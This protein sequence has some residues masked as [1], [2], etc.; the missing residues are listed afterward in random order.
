MN[1]IN[2]IYKL[3]NKNKYATDK[4]K[5]DIN[6]ISNQIDMIILQRGI[7]KGSFF[8]YE[9]LQTLLK[10]N[11]ST[12]KTIV[13]DSDNLIILLSSSLLLPDNIFFNIFKIEKWGP[14]REPK[15]NRELYRVLALSSYLLDKIKE[16]DFHTI[17]IL[18]NLFKDRLDVSLLKQNESNK[19]S[20]FNK[21][22]R[23]LVLICGQFRGPDY[24]EKL[25]NI[26]NS[27]TG[28]KNPKFIIA[29]WGSAQVSQNLMS[30]FKETEWTFR[31]NQQI[32]DHV[33]KIIS[34]G[35]EFMKLMPETYNKLL[36]MEQSKP[37]DTKSIRKIFE[38]VDIKLIDEG[39]FNDDFFT[40]QATTRNGKLNQFKMFYQFYNSIKDEILEKNI[41]NRIVKIRPDNVIVESNLKQLPKL[42][43]NQYLAELRDLY[44]EDSLFIYSG[45][46]FITNTFPLLENI[47][48]NKS[49]KTFSAKD[50]S[51]FSD[52]HLTH[53][54]W[55]VYSKNIP[56]DISNYLKIEY[57]NN[58]DKKSLNF[59]DLELEVKND[60]QNSRLKEDEKNE[61]LTFF[62]DYFFKI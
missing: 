24:L 54:L 47:V 17:I 52:A 16:D 28:L 41:Y 48:I 33:P 56:L 5:F 58:K 44:V 45:E 20:K 2:K 9:D 23:D 30:R 43:R 27:L 25:E 13:K 22:D 53:F 55:D 15:Y 50:I 35:K 40:D 34:I 7:P 36:N 31:M 21:V 10:N 12:L 42:K 51:T 8:S 18:I 14:D 32:R 60:L 59:P 57:V 3:I 61:I 49:L 39:I 46:G 19:L 6:K 11:L 38:D 26:K 4:I 1:R 29:S 37:V 62:T